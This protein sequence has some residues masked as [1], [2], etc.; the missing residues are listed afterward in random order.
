MPGAVVIHGALNELQQW[1]FEEHPH[2]HQ[3]HH[4]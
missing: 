3:R 2:Q 1:V 4:K